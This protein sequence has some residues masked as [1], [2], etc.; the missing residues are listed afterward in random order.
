MR[1]N[2]YGQVY[3]SK[4]LLQFHNEKEDMLFRGFPTLE[5]AKQYCKDFVGTYPQVICT[6]Y[7]GDLSSEPIDSIQDEQYWDLHNKNAEQWSKTNKSGEK[8]A[9]NMILVALILVS[10]IYGLVS[11]FLGVYDIP[12][13][14]KLIILPALTVVTYKFFYWLFPRMF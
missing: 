12:L 8:L 5:D 13:W 3:S 7:E 9:K 4:G 11:H 1:I 2:E 14:L 6:I 10:I